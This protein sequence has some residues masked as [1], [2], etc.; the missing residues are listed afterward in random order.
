MERNLKEYLEAL[1]LIK[2]DGEQYLIRG[3]NV[4][5]TIQ[6]TE[7]INGMHYS[8]QYITPDMKKRLT[9]YNVIC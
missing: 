4:L 5:G 6:S 2:L 8:L 7:T 9:K 1:H 3:K